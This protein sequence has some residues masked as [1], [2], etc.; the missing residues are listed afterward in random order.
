MAA[1]GRHGLTEA[2][3]SRGGRREGGCVQSLKVDAP[4]KVRFTIWNNQVGSLVRR[5]THR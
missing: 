3:T 1:V 4:I 5:T 2:G